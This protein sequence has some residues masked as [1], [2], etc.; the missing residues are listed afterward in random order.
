MKPPEDRASWS[1]EALLAL[2]AEQQRQIAALLVRVE[3]LQA[4]VE[5][6]TREAKRQ[7]APFAKGTRSTTPKRP[8]R[9][10]G[11]GPFRCR[12]AP[13]PAQLTTPP[14]DVP[15]VENI[16]PACGGG[17]REESPE[18]VSLTELPA[19]PRP[20]VTRYRVA[21]CRCMLC[22]QRV[23][24]HHPAVAPD[25][26]GA[27][28][29]RLGDRVM[30]AAHGLH[31]GL[32]GPVRKVPAILTALTGGTLTQGAITQDARRRVAGVVGDLYAQLRT[33]VSAQPVI[34]TDD[35][36][37]R[38]RGAPAYLMAFETDAATVDQIRT[39]PRHEEVQ[40]IIPAT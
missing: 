12:A 23:R 27:T 31:Y 30:A 35:T 36:S 1:R 14:V 19:L 29:H 16:C 34:H 7:A 10:P 24:G 4:D 11:R 28:A 15:V 8:G 37:W 17:L 18:D 40:E 2:I 32:G 22:G 13:P 5:R 9:K 6:L 20:Q 33:A 25:Q 3:V 38:I 39:H 26:Y 21:V